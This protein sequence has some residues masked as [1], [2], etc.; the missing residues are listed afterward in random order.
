MNSIVSTMD[1]NVFLKKIMLLRPID[2]MV[3]KKSTR[4]DHL[5]MSHSSNVPPSEHKGNSSR[6]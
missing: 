6:Y 4:K 2:H 3:Q 5:V 1:T